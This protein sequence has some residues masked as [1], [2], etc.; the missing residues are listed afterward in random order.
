MVLHWANLAFVEPL[1]VG[2]RF[3]EYSAFL[4]PQLDALLKNNRDGMRQLAAYFLD[5]GLLAQYEEKYLERLQQLVDTFEFFVPIFG[6]RFYQV[7]SPELAETK[8]VTSASIEDVKQVYIDFFET[9]AEALT[10][11]VAFNNLVV[12]GDFQSM[13]DRRRDVVTLDDFRRRSKGDRV[14]YLTGD[15]PYDRT[16]SRLDHRLR[17]GLAHNAYVYDARTQDVTYFRSGELNSGDPETFKLMTL[18]DRC[19]DLVTGCKLADELVYQT[20]KIAL[21]GGEA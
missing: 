15:E 6:L 8:F 21:V 5:Q 20:R 4:S 9:C 3:R 16:F 17:N 14:A 13:A 19:W 18:M 7:V 11:V 10:L 1:N 12:R 2:P